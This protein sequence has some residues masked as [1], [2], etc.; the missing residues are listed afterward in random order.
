MDKSQVVTLLQRIGIALELDEANPFEVL[1]YKN[2]AEHLEDWDGDLDQAV[3]AGTL[4]EIYGIGKGIAGV[5]GEL[6]STGRSAK[7]D[8]LCLKYPETLFNLFGVSG[9]GVSKIKRLNRELGI[10]SLDSLEA[11]ASAGRIRALSGFGAKTEERILRGIE[12]VRRRHT[13]SP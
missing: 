1:A 9:L 7:Y 5:I 12:F 8:E 13:E 4:T 10:D 3:A 2:G 6:V 11:A